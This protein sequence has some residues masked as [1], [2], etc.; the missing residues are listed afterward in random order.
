MRPRTSADFT[1]SCVA[2]DPTGCKATA[3]IDELFSKAPE[4]A[5]LRIRA[6]DTRRK[7]RHQ[8]KA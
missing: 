3:K 1:F 6:C 5:H 4:A 8:S 7:G 2:I